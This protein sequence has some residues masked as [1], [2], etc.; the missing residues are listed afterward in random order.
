MADVADIDR[1]KACK[2][3]ED[4]EVNGEALTGAQRGLFGA[5]CSGQPQR[6]AHGALVI[7]TALMDVL[8]ETPNMQVPDEE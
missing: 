8:N 7:N 4:G 2:M 3:L 6:A 5:I 1:E